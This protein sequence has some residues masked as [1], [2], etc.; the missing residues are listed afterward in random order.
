MPG[1]GGPL[2]AFEQRWVAVLLL[3]RQAAAPDLVMGQRM[4]VGTDLQAVG[5]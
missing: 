5:V 4:A 3:P 1:A 2:S